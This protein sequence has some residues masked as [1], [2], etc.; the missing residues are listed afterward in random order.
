M[1]L[2]SLNEPYGDIARFHARL[3][4]LAGVRASDVVLDLGCGMGH[5]LPALL[6]RALEVF[7]L[8]VNPSFLETASATNEAAV[9]D[10]H[11]KLVE[12]NAA[13]GL[14][15]DGDKFDRVICQDMLECL[16][17]SRQP[18]LVAEVHRVLRPGGSLLL[19]HHDYAGIILHS[20]HE[21]M[22]RRLVDA[23][24]TQ[25]QEWMASADGAIGR[26]LPALLA[27][28]DFKDIEIRLEPLTSLQFRA[29]AEASRLCRELI[30]A[31]QSEG[32]EDDPLSLWLAGLDALDKEGGFFLS[33][34]WVFAKAKKG[35]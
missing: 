3:A 12:A 18:D 25:T 33:V 17:P 28:S 9:A 5:S 15:F 13:E 27:H 19:G 14:P 24:A 21:D 29:N 20:K 34:P 4:D 1:P 10:G 2:R 35:R 7:A 11:L 32:I 31:G 23:Y 30:L 26:K 16:P 6:S 8:D 22:T